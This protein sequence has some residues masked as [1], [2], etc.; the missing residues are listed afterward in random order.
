M[1]G[2]FT[3]FRHREFGAEHPFWKMGPFK[4]RIP[5]IHYRWEWPEAIQAMFLFVVNLS[6]I[7]LLQHYFGVPYDVALAYC[8]ITACCLLLPVLLGVP[9]MPGWITPALPI[10][11]LYLQAFTPGQD[12]LK[13]MIALQIEVFIIFIFFGIT[14]LGNKL[15]Q[16]V[17]NS[18]KSG[19]IIGAGI[20]ALMGELKVGGRI[21]ATPIAIIVGAIISAYILF[22]LS[23][24]QILQNSK[25]AKILADLGMIT[26]LLVAMIV[27]WVI[28]EF[29]LPTI[30]WG[31]T[32]PNYSGL[33]EFFIFHTG[34]P[35]WDMFMLAFPTAIIAYMIAFGDILVGKA[36]CDRVDD[37]RTDE[38]I[39]TDIS[40][41]HLVTG[42]RNGIHA[43][44]A[45]WP[46]LA[47][48]LW[49]AAHAT[50][51]ERYSLGRKA[52]ES[53]YS[54]GGS[55]WV[56]NLLAIFI[57]PLVSLFKPVL[58]LALSL[59]LILTA[60]ICIM[61]GMSALKND[62]ERGVAGIVAVTLALPDPKSTIYACVIGIVLYLL[63]ER[64]KKNKERALAE[65]HSN[66]ESILDM[67]E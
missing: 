59:T 38:K 7:P 13:A 51:A 47:G 8:V 62:T 9:L 23:F 20:A 29:P 42:I 57:L 25:I 28:G 26:G 30:E 3:Q 48:P 35:S 6:M 11:I 16:L 14:G 45:P 63:I 31:L 40:R 46:G 54:G 67:P 17:P 34:L 36:L 12:A 2:F 56:I 4:V 21:E 24:K 33:Y 49:T 19:I 53:I 22:S 27:G 64:P 50:V 18:L 52:M 10:V 37:I 61:V 58:P 55:F 60:Y 43:C 1:K 39:D 15:V 66:D 65:N 41:V 5:L 44:V 32:S